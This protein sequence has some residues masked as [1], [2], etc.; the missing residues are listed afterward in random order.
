MFCAE[1][2]VFVASI[3]TA[4]LGRPI[5]RWTLKIGWDGI[6]LGLLT[7]VAPTA[8]LGIL[9]ALAFDP[10]AGGS[11][12]PYPSPLTWTMAIGVA[13]SYAI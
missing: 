12:Q 2:G 3:F 10:L 9:G 4:K 5:P 7:A 13:R 11:R 6:R 1:Q 8:S